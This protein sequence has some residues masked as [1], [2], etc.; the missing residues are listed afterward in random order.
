MLPSQAASENLY[1]AR[2][3]KGMRNFDTYAYVLIKQSLTNRANRAEASSLLRKALTYSPDLPATYFELAKVSFSFSASGILDSMDYIIQGIDAYSR[4]FWWSFAV[5]GSLFFSFILSFICAIAF[6]ILIRLFSDT[7]LLAHDI[8]EN[9]GYALLL[10]A[11][12]VLSIGSPLLFLASILIL[13]GLYM[14]KIDRVVVYLFCLFLFFSPLCFKTASLFFNTISSGRVKAIVSTNESKD[15]DYALSVLRTDDDYAALFSY[16]LALKREGFYDQAISVYKRLLEKKPDPRV[17]VNLG[18]C[19]VGLYNFEEG[20]KHYLNE[21]MSDYMAA[22]RLNPPLA[23]AYYNLSQISR[24]MLDFTKGNEYFRS[25]LALDRVAVSG[26]RDIAGRYPNRITADETLTFS[27]L[28]NVVRSSPSKVSLFRLT[29]FPPAVL[30]FLSL[31]LLA[32]FH[33]LGKSEKDRAYRCRKCDT[34]LCAY[35]EKRLMWRQMC[36]RC[37]GSLIKLDELDV[38]ERVSRLL[39]IYEHQR[40]RRN[41]MKILSFLLPGSSQIYAGKMLYGL[42]FLWPFLF[43]LSI[44]FI[45]ITFVPDSPWVSHNFLKLPA[46]LAAALVYISSNFITRRRIARGWL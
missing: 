44:P 35:C 34:I 21:A 13:L 30:S 42:L 20:K 16:A 45:N 17:Y 14:K 32:S 9:Y 36:P 29:A 43:F 2:L 27:D 41:T 40:R 38:R 1:E 26:Y 3:N 22:T 6:L 33:F 37:Y 24:E 18:N 19:Y 15:N 5:A 12:V 4:N 25:A 8:Q 39:S 11:L 46:L 31:L 23:S 7:P 10:P 28:W